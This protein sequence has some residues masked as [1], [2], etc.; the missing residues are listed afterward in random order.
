MICTDFPDFGKPTKKWLAD[1]RRG[2]SID[3]T[4]H[5]SFSQSGFTLNLGWFRKRV[6]IKHRA[7]CGFEANP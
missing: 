5:L 3:E 2:T 1:G 7:Y 4:V 6:Q